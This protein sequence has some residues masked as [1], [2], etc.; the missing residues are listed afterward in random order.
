MIFVSSLY[1]WKPHA[2]L[3]NSS[4]IVPTE[5]R[6]GALL[7]GIGRSHGMGEAPPAAMGILGYLS[8][9]ATPH[10][11]EIASLVKGLLTIGIP[12]LEGLRIEGLLRNKPLLRDS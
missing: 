9:N 2:F 4:P 8:P 1:C 6:R 7:P 10:P 12:L 5:E 3:W 11:Q